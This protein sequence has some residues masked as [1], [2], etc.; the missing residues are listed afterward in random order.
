MDALPP[1]TGRRGGGLQAPQATIPAAVRGD[2]VHGR[3]RGEGTLGDVIV[4]VAFSE[5]GHVIGCIKDG[6]VNSHEEATIVVMSMV[7]RA[8]AFVVASTGCRRRPCLAASA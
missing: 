6:D 5:W 7:R 8:S 1:E 3:P 4:D 2:R